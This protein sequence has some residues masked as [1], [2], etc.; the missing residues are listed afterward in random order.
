MEGDCGR[1]C[2]SAYAGPGVWRIERMA[3][4]S[5]PSRYHK[6]EKD[7]RAELRQTAADNCKQVQDRHSLLR[8]CDER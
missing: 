1:D 4:G 6:V 2:A 3:H 5:V 7:P 8:V